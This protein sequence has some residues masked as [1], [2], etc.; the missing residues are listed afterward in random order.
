MKPF[1]LLIKPISFTCNLKCSYCFYLRVEKVYPEKKHHHMSFKTLETLI[2]QYLQFRFRESIFGWQG[3]E[4]TLVGLDFF[5]GVVDLQQKYG[6]TGQIIGNALQTN[7]LLIDDEWGQFLNKYKFL[8]GLSLDG[9]KYI[10]DRY[11]KSI[12]GKSVWQ[13][14]MQAVNHLR[15]NRVEFNILCVIS[16]ANVNHVKEIYKFFIENDFRYLQ[17]IPALEADK[18]RK[19]AP[20]SVSAS[21]YGKFLCDLFDEWK[22]APHGVSIRFF[23]GLISHHL[24]YPKGN[25]A[26]EESCA[27]YLLVEWN[28]DIYPCDFFVEPKRKLGNI[29]SDS[30]INIKQK[31]DNG[32][33]LIKQ[34]LGKECTDCKWLDLC[35]GGCIKD[36]AFPDNPHPNRTYYCEAYKKFHNYSNKWFKKF[37]ETLK[38]A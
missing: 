29:M 33:G 5:K 15:E 21:Q 23:D 34:N 28:G 1:Q 7:G 11:R 16:K 10:H 35:Y 14:V 18:E 25:C 22:I 32:F 24:G 2:S 6:L 38:K 3:G 26:L 19:R 9:P 20:F 8:V 17:F 27:D 12:G 37:S 31:R 36:R 30:M 13:K 4:P